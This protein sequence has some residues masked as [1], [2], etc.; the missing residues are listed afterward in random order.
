MFQANAFQNDTNFALK[1][2]QVTA[3]VPKVFVPHVRASWWRRR[4]A[5]LFARMGDD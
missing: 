4:L 5:L 2:F 3:G 1:G